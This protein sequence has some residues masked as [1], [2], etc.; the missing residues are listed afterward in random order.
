[1]GNVT[2]ALTR[3]IG[4]N[5]TTWNTTPGTPS[6]RLIPVVS[7][8]LRANEERETD[9][10]LSGYRG[11]QRSSAGKRE[12]SGAI[13]ITVAPETIGFWL[14]NLIGAPTTTGASA[15]YT[16][17]FEVDPTGA[18]A[19]PVGMGFEVDYGAGISGAGRYIVYSGVRINQMT[20]NLPANGN[21]TAQID[22]LGANFDADNVASLDATP[23]DTGHNVWKAQ[24]AEVVFDAGA[25]SVC[26]E[27]LQ[28]TL[29]NDLDPDRW[30]VGHGGIRHDL[31]EGQFIASGQA[32]AYFDSAA[33]MN[34]ALNDTD[35][36]LVITLTKG[37]GAG[38]A[39]NEELEITI[40]AL[41]FAA[42]TPA[43]DGPRGLKLQADFT[44]H[45]TIGE[46]GV[47]AVLKNALATVY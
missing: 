29:G 42:N 17:T 37:T 43:V 20:L 9:P 33:L 4:W 8:G 3:I 27:S 44:A 12:V 26:L 34:K 14:A 15:P 39:G 25:L 1:M 23:T 46:V 19:L 7:F 16:H 47:T 32:V 21:I 35:A 31:P 13:A 24:K 5:E 30:C 2:G 41:V 38:T 28:V 36:A 45:R 11:Q 18:G 6:A 40:P 22:V 10:T